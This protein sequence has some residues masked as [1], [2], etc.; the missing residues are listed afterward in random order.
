MQ[1]TMETI[2][3]VILSFAVVIGGILFYAKL[4]I[5]GP[6][7]RKT[8]ILGINEN[9]D[10]SLESEQIIFK[11]PDLADDEQVV[12]NSGIRKEHIIIFDNMNR[13][14]FEGMSIPNSTVE[15]KIGS[16]K[17]RTTAN[18]NGFFSIKMPDD[19]VQFTPCEFLTYDKDYKIV[20][21]FKFII[22]LRQFLDRTYFLIEKRG[23]VFSLELSD[24]YISQRDEFN[25]V[26]TVLCKATLDPDLD[27]SNFDITKNK[28]TIVFP[29]N[30]E[31][32]VFTDKR[33]VAFDIED[34]LKVDGDDNEEKDEDEILS[35]CKA[36]WKDYEGT[37]K[38]HTQN[39]Q[40]IF[41]SEMETQELISAPIVN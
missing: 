20:N 21:G 12:I 38:W 16:E 22:V 13:E 7:G 3:A 4:Y 17:I 10:K 30:L 36:N 26:S 15:L 2:T 6:D 8:D 32:L 35:D 19:I 14:Y 24:Q 1:S 9:I 25:T 29:F 41:D 37:L 28:N 39:I 31:S 23:E 5:Y 33:Y 11:P 27:K 40:E 34:N 18:P